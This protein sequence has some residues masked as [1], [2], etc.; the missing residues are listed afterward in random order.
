MNGRNSF[1]SS[2]ENLDHLFWLLRLKLNIGPAI[3]SC[4][5]MY[6]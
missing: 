6:R 3:Q 5:V 2:A 1:R 4:F